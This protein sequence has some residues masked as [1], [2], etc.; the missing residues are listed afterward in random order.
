L[1]I[2]ILGR[3]GESTRVGIAVSAA[4]L[5]ALALCVA[6]IEPLRSGIGDAI[7]GDTESLRNEIED[8]GV[9]G[10]AIVLGLALLHAFVWYPAEIV[11]AAAGFSYGFWS[12][13]AL[14]M[15]GWLLNALLCFW[16]GRTAARPALLRA[17]GEERF[18]RLEGAIQRGGATLLL[19]VRLVPIVPFS[20]SS[21]V[22]GS[23]RVPLGR[24]MWTTLVGYLPITALFVWLG[25]RLEELSLTDPL[26]WATAAILLALLLL[27]RRLARMLATS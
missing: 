10:A 19:A 2:G 26:V 6:L 22:A 11:D 20:L 4:T 24:F 27:T 8:L 14:V 7:Q 16:I 1:R 9:G 3:V 17:L 23:A 5:V 25:T 13:L 18:T 21:Y 12:A 15:A